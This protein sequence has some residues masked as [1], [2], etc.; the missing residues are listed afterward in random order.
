[1]GFA[2]I[3]ALLIPLIAKYGPAFAE[4]VRQLIRSV[5]NAP[6]TTAE[7]KARLDALMIEVDAADERV[8]N[9]PLPGQ[10]TT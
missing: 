7:E 3:L 2:E 9:T 6:A 1:M 5:M 4:Q 8:R 10:R